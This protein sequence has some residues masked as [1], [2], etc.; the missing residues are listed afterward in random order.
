MIEQGDVAVATRSLVDC[1]FLP[2]CVDSAQAGPRIAKT[3]T[4]VRDD[5]GSR[6]NLEVAPPPVDYDNP[7]SLVRPSRIKRRVRY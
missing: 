2:Q 5:A 3:S 4:A 6:P 7:Y 1:F